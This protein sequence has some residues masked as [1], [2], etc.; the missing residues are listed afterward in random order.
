MKFSRR[1][2]VGGLVGSTALSVARAPLWAKAPLSGHQVTGAYRH[3]VGHF[4]VIALNDGM[5]EIPVGMFLGADPAEAG[6][7]LSARSLPSGQSP[8]AALTIR[9]VGS[10]LAT[11][12]GT[13]RRRSGRRP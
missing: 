1:S 5:L 10:G 4:E 11:G 13:S 9:A 2:V 8:T 6:K 12:S 7:L 3:P